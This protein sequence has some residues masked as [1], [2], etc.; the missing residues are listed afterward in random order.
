MT[1]RGLERLDGD[2]CIALLRTHG[3]GRVGT[4]VGDEPLVLPVHYVVAGDDIV[5][6]TDPGAKLIAAVLGTRVAFEV[7]DAQTWSVVVVGHAREL[8]GSSPDTDEARRRLDEHWPAG[9][10]EHLVAVAIEKVTGRR[11]LAS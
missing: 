1:S 7:D 9:E 8:R 3:L 4:R 5:F 6:R 10:R 11:L 2:A